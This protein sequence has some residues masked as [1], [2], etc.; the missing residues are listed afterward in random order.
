[1]CAR[2]IGKQR[3][4]GNMFNS[5]MC[6]AAPSAWPSGLGHAPSCFIAHE[7]DGSRVQ[8]PGVDTVN[9]AVHPLG[10]SKLVAISMQWVTAVEDCEGKRAA[11]RW[12]ACGLCSRMA[13]TTTRWFP[14]FH[15][16]DLSSSV[17][18]LRRQMNNGPYFFLAN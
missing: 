6:R 12:L 7:F 15:T 14:A 3:C 2:Q 10:V 9:Q 8:T 4:H 13:Q 18:C 5:L 11:V 17:S 16:G 1:M